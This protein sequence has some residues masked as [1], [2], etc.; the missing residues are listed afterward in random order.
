MSYER[1]IIEALDIASGEVLTADE[2]FK[3]TKGAFALRTK[4]AKNE[5]DLYCLECQQQLNISG[6]KKDNLHFKHYPNA[7][8][9]ILKDSKFSTKELQVLSKVYRSK[10]SAR[11][12]SLKLLIGEKLARLSIVKNVFVDDRFIKDDREKRKPDVYCENGITKIVFEIQL[13]DLSLRYIIDRHEFYQRNGISLI[14]IL[15][16]FNINGQKQMERDIKYLTEYQNFFA[17]DESSESF[18][19]NC[20]Y[21]YV[22]LTEFYQVYTKWITKSIA[23]SQLKFDDQTKQAYF[24]NYGAKL[25]QMQLL[26]DRRI[27]KLRLK[28]IK[29]E[30]ELKENHSIK[31]IEGLIEIIKSEWISEFPNLK[32]AKLIIQDLDEFEQDLFEKSDLFNSSKKESRIHLY[33]KKAKS[34]HYNFL[35]FILSYKYIEPAINEVSVNKTTLIQTLFE[36]QY[37]EHK[38]TWV[39]KIAIAG[40]KFQLI[41]F[42]LFNKLYLKKKDIEALI[43]LCKLSGSI[44]NPIFKKRLFEHQKLICTMESIK[45]NQIVGFGW[46]QSQWVAF[47]NNAIDN[48]SKYW[49]H[50]ESAFRIYGIWDDLLEKDTKGTFKKKLKSHNEFNTTYSREYDHLLSFLYPEAVKDPN[51]SFF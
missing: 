41:D 38:E 10:E 8:S 36:N 51:Q 21:K 50:I 42:K 34:K 6:S 44:E 45:Q 3:I 1:S 7:N 18:R 12:K 22:Y 47:A 15:D 23:I 48:Y 39:K 26:R 33:F 30:K 5:I 28:K 29:E 46:N 11:H 20:T 40:Y 4:S 37:L 32:Q 25:N 27:E 43:L 19:L 49:N 9:C 16:D 31:K 13:S 24:Y 35:D 2:V 17:L 14:W